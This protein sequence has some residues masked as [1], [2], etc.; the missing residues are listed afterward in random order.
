MKNFLSCLSLFFCYFSLPCGLFLYNI[1]L[2]PAT[3]CKHC[4]TRCLY[5]L[6]QGMFPL[7]CNFKKEMI[8]HKHL[9]SFVSWHMFW[10]IVAEHLKDHKWK[11]K[12]AVALA[13]SY[14]HPYVS[15]WFP[16]P[17]AILLLT[18]NVFS[19]K[20]QIWEIIVRAM[21]WQ[22]HGTLSRTWF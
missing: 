15:L 3:L 8:G 1:I 9:L 19:K 6:C 22:G 5:S 12:L 14:F 2:V 20:I 11:L 10:C 16:T 17:R 18:E 21:I 13:D 7:Q 4:P